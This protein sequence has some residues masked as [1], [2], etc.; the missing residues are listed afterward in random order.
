M[1]YVH[2]DRG[3]NALRLQSKYG[4]TVYQKHHLETTQHTYGLDC[5]INEEMIVTIQEKD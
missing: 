1:T 2:F 4:H 5:H 3:M